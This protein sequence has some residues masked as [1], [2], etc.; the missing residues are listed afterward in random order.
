[1]EQYRPVTSYHPFVLIAFHLNCLPNNLIQAIPRSTR[2][3]WIHSDIQDSFGFGWYHENKNLFLTLELI[4]QN[5]KLLKINRALLRV[6]A[7]K[8]F[9][10]KNSAVITTGLSS[11][12]MAAAGNILKVSDVL[13]LRKA[14]KYL[15]ID[16]KQYVNLRKKLSCPS[17][18]YD[19]CFIKHPS[20][21][22]KKEIAVIKSYCADDR[23]LHWPLISVYHQIKKDSV[24]YISSSTFYK[25]VKLLKLERSK[26]ISRR[27]NHQIGIRDSKPLEIIHADVTILTMK[28]NTRAFIY[29][30][31]DNFAGNRIKFQIPCANGNGCPVF[32]IKV[33]QRNM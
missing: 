5:K 10:K 21:L 28:D 12:K 19:L 23:F 15:D 31:Q 9:I 6:I 1:M 27:K 3:D 4:T 8:A 20:Q 30:L 25:Y 24:A 14:L 7:L 26:A 33:Y 18:I 22:L 11:I 16:F 17:S 13:G 2:F 29:L 32:L